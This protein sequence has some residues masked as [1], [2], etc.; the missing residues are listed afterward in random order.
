MH[1][2][3]LRALLLRELCA[4]ALDAPERPFD[5]AGRGVFDQN[6]WAASRFGPHGKLVHPDR[7]EAVGVPEL[8]RELPVS[9][10][11]FDGA[12]CEADRQL[13]MGR[14]EGLRAVCADLVERSVASVA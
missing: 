12:S 1:N 3:S 13:E 4:W 11:G 8:L 10:D 14:A 9:A 6:R 2:L 7:D 5:P